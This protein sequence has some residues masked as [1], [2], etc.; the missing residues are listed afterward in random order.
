MGE[1]GNGKWQLAFWL[2]TVICG[3]WLLT[4][5]QGV[6]AN[7][8]V[9]TEEHKDITKVIYTQ[10]AAIDIKLARLETKLEK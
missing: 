6:I 3:V 2:I 5:T 4:L 10:L 1:N 7:D 9:N 8:R